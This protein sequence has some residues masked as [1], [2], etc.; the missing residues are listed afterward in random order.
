MNQLPGHSTTNRQ[1]NLMLTLIK[2]VAIGFVTWI[3]GMVGGAIINVPLGLFLPEKIAAVTAI[4]IGVVGGFVLLKD[5][6]RDL[7]EDLGLVKKQFKSQDSSAPA[8]EDKP[9]TSK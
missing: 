7:G 5:S 9:E 3:I 2:L 8:A 4:V 6:W 1:R